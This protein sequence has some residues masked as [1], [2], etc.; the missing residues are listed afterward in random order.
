MGDTHYL[1]WITHGWHF[2]LLYLLDS[3]GDSGC[4][5][6]V[7]QRQNDV[8]HIAENS[9][10][11]QQQQQQQQQQ[12]HNMQNGNLQIRKLVTTRCKLLELSLDL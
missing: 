12:Q 10:Q 1:L 8:Q 6:D 5:G 3:S 4:E 11:R 2:F 7:Q 9:Q